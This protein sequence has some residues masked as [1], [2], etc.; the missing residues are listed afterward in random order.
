MIPDLSEYKWIVPDIVWEI[1]EYID[2]E[3]IRKALPS[4]EDLVKLAPDFDK[5]VESLSLLKDFFTS[6]SPEETAFRA[7]DRGSESDKHFRK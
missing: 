4:S 3:K 2:F 1:D 5:I 6:G 7:T